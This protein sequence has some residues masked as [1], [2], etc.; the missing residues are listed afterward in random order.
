MDSIALVLHIF[1]LIDVLIDQNIHR[2]HK[3]VTVKMDRS[4]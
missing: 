4:R 3:V 1:Q 2:S